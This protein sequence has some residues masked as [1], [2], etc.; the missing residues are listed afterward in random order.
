MFFLFRQ[1]NSFIFFIMLAAVS[2][3]VRTA[4]VCH[5]KLVR[6]L[7]VGIFARIVRSLS[8]ADA[9]GL[10]DDRRNVTLRDVPRQGGGFSLAMVASRKPRAVLSLVIRL[11]I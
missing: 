9:H 4:F 11:Y 3:L 2:W 7:T 10:A 5:L 1:S 6:S 8:G